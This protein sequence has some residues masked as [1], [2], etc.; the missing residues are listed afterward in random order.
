MPQENR[1]EAVRTERRRKPGAI[2]HSGQAFVYDESQLDRKNYEYR[3][4]N[5]TK[6]RLKQMEM[7][8]W[9]IAPEPA[10]L[11]NTSGG[12]AQSKHAGV[13]ELGTYNSVLMRK[14]K[15]MHIEDQQAKSAHLDQIEARIKSGELRTDAD[16][17][18]AGVY[19]PGG[20]NTIEKIERV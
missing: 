13:N 6:G 11:G 16:L 17:N 1:A 7:Q 18:G 19:T 12:T 9:D 14:P 15:T 10:L 5:D 2:E 20:R 3:M 8:D 4:V